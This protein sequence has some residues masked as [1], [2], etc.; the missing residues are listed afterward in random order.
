MQQNDISKYREK[1]IS[2][3]RE[4]ERDGVEGLISW[5]D[6]KSDFFTAPASAKTHTR[7]G[8]SSTACPFTAYSRIFQ[9]TYR[10]RGRIR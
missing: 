6:E 1:Y 5:L 2:L 4:T 10:V 3:L 9:R 8:W 7:A